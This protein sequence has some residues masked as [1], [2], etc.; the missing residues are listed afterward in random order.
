MV[1]GQLAATRSGAAAA[2]LLLAGEDVV[3]RFNLNTIVRGVLHSGS[4]G[5]WVDAGHLRR[6]LAT[7]GTE[8]VAV[9]AR[10]RGLHRLDAGTLVDNTASQGVLLGC[11]FVEYGLAPRYLFLGGRWRD[12]RLFQRILHDEP[13]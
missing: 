6:G 10:E 4:L 9:Q 7:A 13:L 8:H 11:G 1:A 2:W 5:Y 3:G 12:H